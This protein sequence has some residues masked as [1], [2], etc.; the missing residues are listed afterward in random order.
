MSRGFT[1]IEL[2]IVVAIIGILAAIALPA[3][4][5]YV[6]TSADSA[7]LVEAKH[8]A[9]DALVRL[10][11]QLTPV[12]PVSTGAC[13]SYSGANATLT[14]TGSFTANPRAPGSA[15]VTCNLATGGSCSN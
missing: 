5:N 1:L 8:Y 2:M 6:R 3:Y 12:T 10:N 7:C 14:L 15:V 11:N 4:Q 9:H 13:E